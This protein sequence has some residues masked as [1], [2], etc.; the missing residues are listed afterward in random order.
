M[1]ATAAIRWKR[2]AG[3]LLTLRGGRARMRKTRW[4][5]R[6]GARRSARSSEETEAR[7]PAFEELPELHKEAGSNGEVV[8]APSPVPEHFCN[9]RIPRVLLKAINIITTQLIVE[10]ERNHRTIVIPGLVP[11][12]PLFARTHNPPA[13]ANKANHATS[14]ALSPDVTSPCPPDSQGPSQFPDRTV[15][16]IPGAI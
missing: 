6:S 9:R 5:K 4:C 11:L 12:P 1:I 3:Q 16:P 10:K 2:M 7:K 8:T 13:K 14:I 15:A